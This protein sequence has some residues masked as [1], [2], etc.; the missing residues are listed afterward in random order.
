MPH[1]SVAKIFPRVFRE[2]VSRH[3][4]LNDSA[5][6]ETDDVSE[7][8]PLGSWQDGQTP[9]RGSEFDTFNQMIKEGTI[10]GLSDDEAAQIRTQCGINESTD[11][12]N[13]FNLRSFGSSIAAQS[14][15]ISVAIP[16]LTSVTEGRWIGLAVVYPLLLARAILA[17]YAEHD[18]GTTVAL[19]TKKASL[20]TPTLRNGVIDW[21]DA[22]KLVPGDI[23]QLSECLPVFADGRVLAA[24]ESFTVNEAPVPG[25]RWEFTR[26]KK[27]DMVYASSVVKSGEAFVLIT[28][29]GNKRRD[30]YPRR[31]QTPTLL[32]H[33]EILERVFKIG[34]VLAVFVVFLTWVAVFG[35]SYDSASY[36]IRE[37]LRPIFSIILV[38]IPIG[39]TAAVIYALTGVALYL[40]AHGCLVRRLSVL[41]DVAG[42]DTLCCD[43]TGT[44]TRN[45]LQVLQPRSVMRGVTPEDVLV[46]ASLV[47]SGNPNE[48]DVVDRA[49][50]EETRNEQ[51]EINQFRKVKFFPFDPYIKKSSSIVKTPTGETWLYCK[52]APLFVLKDCGV[53]DG[54]QSPTLDLPIQRYRAT[55]DQI[56]KSG[57]PCMGVAR[58]KC[59]ADG[60]ILPGHSQILGLIPFI[61]LA[62][63]DSRQRIVDIRQYG[64]DIKVF[65]MN[66][67]PVV[68][69][70][71]YEYGLGTTVH[72]MDELDLLT[73]STIPE[74]FK[75]NPNL[76]YNRI[77]DADAF[78]EVF[79][80]HKYNVVETLE[81]Y[82]RCVAVTADA[83]NECLVL[84]RATVGIAVCG[85]ADGA[86]AAADLVC[87]N[88]GFGLGPIVEAIHASRMAFCTIFTQILY[89]ATA[90][91]H[92]L[93][94][95]AGWG[96]FSMGR[97]SGHP[98][99]MLD[100]TL[101]VL[102]ILFSD[103][104]TFAA[105]FDTAMSPI[106][107]LIW[108]KLTPIR[109]CTTA[110]IVLAVWTYLTITTIPI[111]GERDGIIVLDREMEAILF[112]QIVLS[113]SM[114]SLFIR[115]SPFWAMK[116]TKEFSACL[117]SAWSSVYQRYIP[118]AALNNLIS[119]E[120]VLQIV[121][122]DETLESSEK[123]E[124]SD[125][126]YKNAR[127]LF[128]LFV[129]YG[130]P[131][132]LLR[133]LPCADNGLPMHEKKIAK[134]SEIDGADFR[135][136]QHIPGGQWIFLAPR[137]SL[138][139]IH[140][141]LDPNVIL[142]F[143]SMEKIGAGASG[144]VY[145]V[146]IEPSHLNTGMEQ[147]LALKV[148]IR[149]KD[150]DGMDERKRL[151]GIRSAR[152]P[153]IIE[154]FTSFEVG[155]KLGMFFPLAT[156]DL[157]HYMTEGPLAGAQ[158]SSWFLTQLRGLTDALSKIHEYDS[159]SESKEGRYHHSVKPEN[160][161]FFQDGGMPRLQGNFKIADFGGGGISTPM[162]APPEARR[163]ILSNQYDMWSFGCVF[164]ELLVWI[165]FGP[166]A[167]RDLVA[168][169]NKFFK[170]SDECF[171][172]HN[173]VASAIKD[174][175]NC[176]KEVVLEG[177]LEAVVNG[178][179]IPDP[180][181]RWT[182]TRLLSH[183]DM[184]A[185]KGEL[186]A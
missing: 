100:V 75:K 172:L 165:R 93:L 5:Q 11:E 77:K 12:R 91:C 72:R 2:W 87:F 42:V 139:G 56:R 183:F 155:G 62:R 176:K 9:P 109:T 27:G 179:L 71:S 157:R 149:S 82:G 114:L 76:F 129:Y 79:P 50:L 115:P 88:Q 166:R 18:A 34:P 49:I 48:H 121:E 85:A 174:L 64:L 116:P 45:H 106:T 61:D 112:L 41:E 152:H 163:G 10:K 104:F 68:E 98:V 156:C 131:L 83:A 136:I 130:L 15:V 159:N 37:L 25:E 186:R 31:S 96:L 90:V 44:L 144:M 126:L 185:G 113:Q 160:I 59:T 52:G 13:R 137:F 133:M 154:L 23:V 141:I 132:A 51:T 74:E 36:R 170:G 181:T 35:R 110:A 57:Y 138:G 14:I 89:R 153:H 69:R 119:E 167:R 182:P 150:T 171:D 80:Q 30:A 99:E 78:P 26:K 118:R 84:R 40:G 54:P 125:Y 53:T 55:V 67:S 173:D 8:S 20:S 158:Y 58:H 1:R 29:I 60:T 142:P 95:F 146:E 111:H 16:A 117:Q 70:I 108:S 169:I 184:I 143:Q 43:Y 94:C 147:P 122:E 134:F 21:I 47:T 103:C 161:L 180:Q 128:A 38:S 140:Q 105:A 7:T 101:V 66:A 178:L 164:L 148:I 6:E 28:A 102:I 17:V 39:L 135:F 120:S 107:P 127:V 46:F 73:S 22:S 123:K 19:L 33:D 3:R 162:Y 32:H 81:N 92:M 4:S 24:D 145:R 124:F 151:E 63:P 168:T 86:R 65:S 177:I 175:R 97:D